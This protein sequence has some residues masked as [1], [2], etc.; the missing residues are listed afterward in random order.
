MV[1]AHVNTLRNFHMFQYVPIILIPENQSGH[2]HTNIANYVAGRGNLRVLHQNGSRKAGVTKTKEITASYVTNMNYAI[3]EEDIAFDSQWFSN[4]PIKGSKNGVLQ[5]LRDQLIRYGKDKNGRYTGKFDSW[6]DDLA[7]AA[8]M[9][10]FWTMMV[11][12]N[13]VTNPYN[14]LKS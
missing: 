2:A 14:D 6:Q 8:M 9:F 1:N 4:T 12:R 5:E 10:G 11:E 7:I 13:D 3:Q